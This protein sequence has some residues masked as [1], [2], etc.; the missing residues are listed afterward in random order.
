MTDNEIVVYQSD[1][2]KVQLEINLKGNNLWLDRQKISEL[3]GIDRSVVS[4]HIKNIFT[5]GEVE[6][7][8][9]VQKMH[10]SS[11]DKPVEIFSL[12]IILAVGYRTNSAIAIRFR[13][14]ATQTL[15][16]YVIKG[17]VIDD[18]RLKN[19]QGWD[20]FDELLERIR[21]IR[22]SEKRFYQKIRDL[23][24]LSVDYKDDIK[25][26]N[27]FFATVQNKLLY[28]VTGNTA[29]ELITARADAN[30]PNMNLTSWN[31]SRVRK[32]DV[33]IAKNYLIQDEIKKLDRLVTMFLDYAEDQ[34]E[35]RRQLK[36]SDWKDKVDKFLEFNDYEILDNAGSIS[37]KQAE[38]IAHKRFEEFNAQRRKTEAIEADKQDLKELEDIETR[39]KK[40]K[41]I[42]ASKIKVS[43][44]KKE[45]KE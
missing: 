17:F 39:V 3:F 22:A 19:P 13:Q 44:K 10:I 28:A 37:K 41:K 45:V 40:A 6:E 43:P 38:E 35:R 14:W 27:I 5:D 1:D 29:A 23:F 11:S 36:M 26:S 8:S 33:I 31:G 24:T 16:E 9:N 20:Y 32:Q 42:E 2:G 12:D 21:E 34:A 15:K 30:S 4:K 7:K 18:E 25:T